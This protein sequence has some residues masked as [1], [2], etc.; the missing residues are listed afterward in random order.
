MIKPNSVLEH[1]ATEFSAFPS[2]LHSRILASP[3]IAGLIWTKRP[4]SGFC[5]SS[6]TV[7]T[8][9]IFAAASAN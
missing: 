3:F 8:N 5:C 1:Y 4:Q 2:I 6:S 9:L 7:T